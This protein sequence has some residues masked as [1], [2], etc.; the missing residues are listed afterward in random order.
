MANTTPNTLNL[1]DIFQAMVR[2]PLR[3][4]A[5]TLLLTVV[6]V[7]Y[8]LV[9]PAT[10]QASQALL[11]RDEAA[12]DSQRPG[13][14]ATVDEMK[15]A[16]ETVLELF[17]SYSVVEAALK[18]VGAPKN[19][20]QPSQWPTVEDVE[21]MQK[22]IELAA[23]NGAEFGR[24]EIFY[25]NVTAGSR[26]RALALTS[27][28]G[29]QLENRMQSLRDERASGLVVELAKTA[30]VADQELA[31]TTARLS[32]LEQEVGSDLAEL[33]ILNENGSGGSNLRQTLIEIRAEIRAAANERR[34]NEEL[35]KLLVAAQQDPAIIVATPNRLLES[36]PGLRR[37]KDGL[38]DAQ[39]RTSELL[40]TMSAVHPRVAAAKAAE[41]EIRHHLHGELEIAIRGIQT[42]LSVGEARVASLQQHAG[43]IE[44][45]MAKLAGLRAE[46]QNRVAE[47]REQSSIATNALKDLSDARANQASAHAASLIT[48]LD[49]PR[50]GSKPEGPGRTVIALTGMF[51]GLLTGLGILFLTVNPGVAPTVA[52][53]V[54][55]TVTTGEATAETKQ[56]R[57]GHV[58]SLTLK[59]ALQVLQRNT[60]AWG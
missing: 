12:G 7:G 45:R 13:H 38:V 11:V 36:Q 53:T 6:A 37:L 31:E 26:E 21:D 34:A 56:P 20:R 43:D 24:T 57:N 5:P 10:W 29:R 30:K 49:Q 60:P 39:L 15:T 44:S 8:A 14:F 40:G 41:T 35:L 32:A 51:G 23:P 46:Y 2:Y 4:V 22:E 25:L 19:Y 55:P 54:V 16:Q 3:W 28:L 42:E 50:T 59:E 27:A 47:Q 48:R 52:E 17:K 18:E 1:H 33:R 9:R 58:G